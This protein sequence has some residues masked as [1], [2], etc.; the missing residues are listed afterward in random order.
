MDY[1][2]NISYIICAYQIRI[3]LLSYVVF[4][5]RHAASYYK[6]LFGMLF[7]DILQSAHYPIF[8]GCF[9]NAGIYNNNIS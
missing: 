9:Y 3:K 7:L 5:F 8:C 2:N 6:F 1:I 4:S